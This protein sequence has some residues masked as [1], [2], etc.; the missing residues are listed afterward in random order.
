MPSR[1]FPF[2]AVVIATLSITTPSF[3]ALVTMT[4]T[5]GVARPQ[6]Q[7]QGTYDVFDFFYSAGDGSLNSSVEFINYRVIATTVSGSFADPARLQDDRQVN[8][9]SGASNGNTRGHVDT[10]MNTVWSAAAKDDLGHFANIVFNAG[11]YVPSGSGVAPTPITRIDWIVFDVINEDDNNLNNADIN[12]PATA[13]APYHL[14]RILALPGTFATFELQMF[15]NDQ[16]G[17][18]ETFNFVFLPPTPADVETRHL[19]DVARGS[20][21][22]A[23]LQEQNF[24]NDLFDW[25]LISFNGAGATVDPDTGEFTWDSTGAPL[26]SYSAVIRAS[27]FE[28]GSDE[29]TLTFN[30]IPEP[31][32]TGL[33]SLAMVGGLGLF[34][35]RSG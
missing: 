12:G 21:V 9:Q 5:P 1:T 14:A 35:R 33:L 6:T 18:P 32:S 16:L 26:G 4:W 22:S 15:E 8:P 23:T 17:V 28:I 11:S 7:G 34:R 27:H 13:T 30:L 2:A 10:W 24:G 31:A 3:A 20:I 29:G 25:E 19:G